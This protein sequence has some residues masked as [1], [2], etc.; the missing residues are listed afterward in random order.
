[1]DRER[2]SRALVAADAAGDTQA[3]QTLAREIRKLDSGSFR[4]NLRA[5]NPAEYDPSSSEYQAKYGPA[6][7]PS[8][9]NRVAGFGRSFVRTGEG[10]AQ[11]GAPLLD[12]VAPRSRG[13]SDIIT[14]HDPS[15]SASVQREIDARKQRDQPLMN[16]WS[17][18]IGD[19][20]G[21]G[22]QFAL[23]G[24]ALGKAP[25]LLG[26]V[27]QG[28]AVGAALANTQ[29]VASDE[30]RIAN[31]AWGAGG[32]AF[33]ELLAA[34][35]G[36]L[37]QGA[38]DKVSPEVRD[39][40]NKAQ[41]LG[42]PLRAE[43]VTGSRPMAGVSA[44]L[45]SVPFSGR[46]ASRNAQRLAFNRAVA[47]TIG[48]NTDNVATAV[49]SAEQN[50]GA[51]YDTI[52]KA[53]PVRADQQLVSELDDALQAARNELTDAQFG[54]MQRQ[55]DQ[56]LNKVGPG[57]TI[58]AQAAY[59]IKKGLDRIGRSNDSSLAYHAKE[60]RDTVLSALDRSLPEDVA[61]QFTQTRGQYANLITIRRLVRAG[62]EGNVTPAM[63]GNAKV[64]GD[65]KTV[66]DIGAQFLREPFGNSGT[67]NRMVGA[68]LV[69]GLSVGA[70]FN[71]LLAAKIAATGGT[72][73]RGTNALLQSPTFVQYQLQ[74]SNALR[75]L[76]PYTNALLPAL[77][78]AGAVASQ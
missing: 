43:Q 36:R 40:A 12:A 74:G 45:D 5:S 33:G 7:V 51:Q 20:V 55:V 1:M 13:L 16:T 24:G 22:T 56:I 23:P 32:G 78:T 26:R 75:G 53:Y 25:S 57:D 10:I 48:E 17:G 14:G 65:L 68:G 31:T 29:P 72:V 34:G 61:Q 18:K 58:D 41:E 44:A 15:W 42:I 3:A 27:A 62:A 6:A 64:R 21:Q 35:I 50:L 73:G 59:N 77:G 71:P 63:L 30:S 8:T 39:L 66:A 60:L 38:S 70:G 54:V 76:V 47:A 67:A 69:S 52:L 49:H 4:A 46:D 28:A 37:A 9:E 2:L 11:L 19:I